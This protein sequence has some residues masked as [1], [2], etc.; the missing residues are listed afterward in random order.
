MI[1]RT[2]NDHRTLQDSAISPPT[3]HLSV[4]ISIEI[5]PVAVK[6][7]WESSAYFDC[8]LFIIQWELMVSSLEDP[9]RG[10]YAFAV[11]I[12][13]RLGPLPALS[14]ESWTQPAVV[15]QLFPCCSGWS[16]NPLTYWLGCKV[17][18]SERLPVFLFLR[19]THAG[20]QGRL[21]GETN[22]LSLSS[23]WSDKSYTLF[24]D[25]GR[26]DWILALGYLTNSGAVSQICPVPSLWSE[27]PACLLHFLF[28]A[29]L[30]FT[31]TCF[32]ILSLSPLPD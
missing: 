32:S 26:Q 2:E 10:R 20:I 23:Q 30:N 9:A 13:C 21:E 16:S 18:L 31:F 15:F 22:H 17:L 6:E 14:W 25:G 7:G 1:Y 11:Q 5:L 28:S 4:S 19:L 3:W 27:L 29:S 8:S 24:Q 12:N